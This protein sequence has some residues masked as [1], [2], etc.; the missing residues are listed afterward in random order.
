ML[1]HILCDFKKKDFESV[2][3]DIYIRVLGFNKLGRSYLN[4]V[5]KD[6]KV[7]IISKVNKNKC[8]LLEIELKSSKIYNLVFNNTYKEEYSCFPVVYRKDNNN[9]KN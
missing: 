1:L 3:D 5:K 9:Y 7:P 6:V 2:K 8:T 4:C